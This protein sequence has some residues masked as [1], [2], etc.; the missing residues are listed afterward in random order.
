VSA[1]SSFDYAIVRVVP[2][3]ERGEFLNAGAILYSS[4]LGYLGARIALD[5]ARLQA[6]APGVDV[7][8]V[9]RALALIPL[10]CSGAPGSGPVGALSQ[11]ER[12][13]WLTAPRSTVVQT[14]AV[15]SGL[16]TEPERMLESLLRT[17][18]LPPT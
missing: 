6:F 12:F 1:K 16:C 2:R 14:S 4:T 5:R 18:V 11:T 17:M 13:H 7:E 3:V 10:V 9:E 8:D 15:H